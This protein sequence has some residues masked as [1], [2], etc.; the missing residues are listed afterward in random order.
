MTPLGKK[1]ALK[2]QVGAAGMISHSRRI[3]LFVVIKVF[4]MF[5]P[6]KPPPHISANEAEEADRGRRWRE[7]QDRRVTGY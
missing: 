5:V 4:R 1:P 2:I 3:G 7:Q 6:D